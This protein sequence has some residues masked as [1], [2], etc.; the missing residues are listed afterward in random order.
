MRANL[1]ELDQFLGPYPYATLKKWISLT[2][3]ISEAT[4]EKLQP[5]NRQICAFSDV[6]PVL[7]M[8]HTKDR[9]G[10]NLPAVALSA[11]ATKR[12]WPGYQR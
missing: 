9:V 2:N 7:S 11:R 1:Q 8:K 5:E 3:F 6:L 10:Q 12:A 4:V